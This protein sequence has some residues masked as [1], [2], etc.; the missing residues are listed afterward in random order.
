V[1]FDQRVARRLV[2]AATAAVSLFALSPVAATAAAPAGQAVPVGSPQPAAGTPPRSSATAAIVNHPRGIIPFRQNGTNGAFATSPSA[3]LAT[4]SNPNCS[5]CRPPLVFHS[6][7]PVA[8]GLTATA[9][10]VTITPVYWAPAGYGYTANYKAIINGYIANVAADSQRTTNVYSPGTQYYQQLGGPIQNIQYAITAGTEISDTTAYPAGCSAAAGFTACVTDGAL[11]TE[12]LANL[13]LLSRP[14]DD[15]HLYM[16]M[17]PQQV[18]TCLGSSCSSNAYCAYHNSN[19]FSAISNYLL[20][21]NEPFPDLSHCTGAEGPQAPNGDAEA[22]ALVNTFSHEANEIITDWAGAWQDSANPAYESGDECAYVFGRSSG[23]TTTVGVGGNL[24]NQVINGAHY[25]TQDEFSNKDFAVSRGDVVSDHVGTVVYGCVQQDEPP[26]VSHQLYALTGSD[27]RTW[28]PIDKVNLSVTFTPAV[29]ALASVSGNAD[30]YTDTI[31]YNQD[32]G[33]W[34]SGGSYGAGGRLVAWKESGGFAGT[35]SPN[36]AVVQTVQPAL[37][38]IAYTAALVWKTNRNA[39][40][41]TI[42]SGA[43]PLPADGLSPTRLTAQWVPIASNNLDSVVSNQLYALPSSDGASWQ[44]VDGTGLMPL[45]NPFTPPS[46]T[47]MAVLSGNADLY[48]DTAGYNQDIGLMLSGGAYGPSPGTLVAWKESGGFAG[49]FSPNAAF[50]QSVQPVQA[51]TT[52]AV[53]LVWKTNRPATGVTIRS[54]AGPDPTTGLIS[55]TRL[56]AQLLPATSVAAGMN[57]GLYQFMDSDGTTWRE[58]DPSNLNFQFTP[59]STGTYLLSGNADLY[60]NSLGYNQD[61]A[62]F[63]S[64]GAYGTSGMLVAW[65]ES[66]GFGGTFSPN[67]AYVEA[68]ANLTASTTYTIALRWKTNKQSS[69]NS[70]ISAGA[71]PDP[72]T[73][74][75]SPTRLT[76][77]LAG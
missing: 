42:R 56:T 74:L 44:T 34:L 53:R 13:R 33:L 11:Q 49:T 58:M 65:K 22:D 15:A 52:Y 59:V 35:F 19:Y 63:I 62:I 23:G 17:F 29:D 43:G 25:Y 10:Q 39:P 48:T 46:G 45:I 3:G 1:Q 70:I 69:A 54:G 30:L 51:G 41:V 75:I 36:A 24:Y 27:G 2:A 20:Y 71:G 9:G 12:L 21:A 60:T 18:E 73:H 55:P 4:G 26:G 37:A 76:A 67:A 28:Q 68:A 7:N 57:N 61:I 31:G 47:S 77:V 38:G 16:V 50:V 66:G 8:G 64:G 6:G 40:G 5:P 32:I 14:I 72:G